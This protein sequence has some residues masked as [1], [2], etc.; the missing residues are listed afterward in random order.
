VT[1]V[2]TCALPILVLPLAVQ[3]TGGNPV[4]VLQ[5]PEDSQQDPYTNQQN[6]NKNFHVFQKYSFFHY[7]RHNSHFH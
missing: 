5:D 6:K 4:A 2:Q 1:G 3:Q 7:L